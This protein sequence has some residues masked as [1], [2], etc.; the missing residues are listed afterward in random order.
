LVAPA[1]D[2]YML[3]RRPMV[4]EGFLSPKPSEISTGLILLGADEKGGLTQLRADLDA[5]SGFAS[6]MNMAE[7]SGLDPTDRGAAT[8]GFSLDAAYPRAMLTD[9]DPPWLDA[10]AIDANAVPSEF[11]AP[12]R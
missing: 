5:P 9:R 12:G 6:M 4:L 7:L 10:A 3:C 1:W 2:L 8:S 11:V